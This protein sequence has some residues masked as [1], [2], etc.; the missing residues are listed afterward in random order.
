[1]K[2]IISFILLLSLWGSM[3]VAEECT[4]TEAVACQEDVL[5]Q[6]Q[7]MITEDQ[8]SHLGIALGS[9]ERVDTIP[10]LYVPAKVVIP[11]NQDHIVSSTLAGLVSKL[12]VSIGDKVTQ[13]QLLATL[14]SPELL[15]QQRQYLK[16]I[17]ELRLAQAIMQRDKKMLTE[18]IIADKRWDETLSRYNIADLEANEAKQLL[19]ISG[20]SEQAIKELASTRRLSSHLTI[21]A[22]ASGVILE[23]MVSVGARVDS[24][25]ALFRLANIDQLW[26]QIKI[27]QERLQDIKV[28]DQVSV[29][30]TAATA[31]ITLLGQSVDPQNQ[32]VLARAQINAAQTDVRPGQNVNTQIIKKLERAAYVVPNEAITQNEG[33]AYIFVKNEPGFLA[34]PV[35]ILGKQ[36][37]VTMVS[38][39]FDGQEQIAVRG[40]VALKA[41]WLGLGSEE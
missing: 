18:G 28:G 34:V 11:P 41:T 25:S 26:L 4:Q 38:G 36:D 35:E 10:L 33:H 5:N 20:M 32:T 7:L 8:F 15:A 37:A 31:E 13:G 14:S 2:T 9:L 22:P 30:N 24:Q 19:Q 16:L 40:S 29:V 23:S 1:M 6:H 17:S 12:N 21:T 39:D 27:P 3:A